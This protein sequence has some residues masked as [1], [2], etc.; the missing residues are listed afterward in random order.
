MNDYDSADILQ[1]F[2]RPGEALLW[3]GRP[4]Q[5]VRLQ[6]AD[7]RLI[8]FSFAWLA[9]SVFWV[10]VVVNAESSFGPAFAVFGIPFVLVG[11][12]LTLGRFYVDARRRRTIVYG[13]TDRRIIIVPDASGDRVESIELGRLDEYSI[14][15]KN[16]G[17][18]TIM[19]GASFSKYPYGNAAF[20]PFNFFR[21]VTAFEGIAE[22]KAVSDMLDSMRGEFTEKGQGAGP[23]GTFPLG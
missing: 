16:D 12:Y 14:K 5:G 9:F 11:L 1:R 7:S 21:V 4:A 23:D 13:L 6:A 3:S 2:L 17:S 10:G 20:D 22:A 19:F 18:G 15:T 8:P